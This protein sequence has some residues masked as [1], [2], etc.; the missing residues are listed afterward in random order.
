MNHG[1]YVFAQ[2]M[3][4]ISSRRFNR[5]VNAYGGHYRT[6]RFSCWEQ[7]LAMAFG[8]I[9]H[10][11][12]VRDIEACLAAHR[13][14]QYHLG[15]RSAV[16]KSTLA[17]A[18]KRRDWR[19]YR[20]FA[21]TLI[22][23]ARRLYVDDPSFC[24]E[25]DGAC[26]ALDSTSIDL[27]LS[28]FPWAPY[29]ETKAAVKLHT[30]M[31][32]RGSIP[33]F[34]DITS[35]NVHDVHLLDTI[36]YEP[37]AHYVMDRGY[38]DYARLYAITEARAFFVIR[39]R[40]NMVWK[41]LYSHPVDRSTGLRCDQTVRLTGTGARGKYPALLRRIKYYDRETDRYYVFITNDFHS[42]AQT[43]ADLYRYR[44]Q[45]ELFFKWIK[46]HLKIHTFW[47]V[48]ENAVKTQ[49]C[50]AIS[51]Y[52]LV[53][54]VKKRLS[55]FRPLSEMLQ[56]LSTS[57]FDKTPLAE[58]FSDQSVPKTGVPYQNTLPLSGF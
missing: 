6:K 58:L 50:T 24:L 28:L 46:Q 39:A 13:G 29:V 20:D 17:H 56:I 55:I 4:S 34:F 42:P 57:L 53:A 38:T 2:L 8:Q 22:A 35:G 23:E 16:K 40:G 30:Q 15:F 1:T 33:T 32:I 31:D 10:R 52:L 3:E 37:G 27:C 25:L 41:R 47:G 19:I 7:F 14:K 54:I 12:S 21:E 36:I 48:S 44:W 51:T 11:E 5:C 18:N 43:I 49:I 45:I 9:A 26:Y